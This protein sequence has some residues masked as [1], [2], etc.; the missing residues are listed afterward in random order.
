MSERPWT[1]L[2]VLRWTTGYLERHASTSPRLDAELLL[3]EVLGEPRIRLYAEFNRPLAPEERARYRELVRRRARGEP[4]QYLLERQEFWSITLHVRPGVPVP[5]ADTEVLVEEAL[6][7]AKRLRAERAAPE[8]PLRIAEVGTGSGCIAIA[9]AHELPEAR[10]AAGDVEPACLGCAHGNVRAT[11][12]EERV[13]VFEA[14][15][16]DELATASGEEGLELV[17]SNP[18]YL[19]DAERE[20]LMREVREHEPGTALFAG[21]SGLEILRPVV[22]EAGAWL[23]AGG[24]LAVEI[25][26]DEQ[27]AAVG[28][29]MREQGFEAVR[30][31]ADYG[32]ILRVVVGRRPAR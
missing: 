26:G 10:V 21:E 30:T 24:A 8:A 20:D 13:R 7:E 14:D 11:G 31:R 25:G 17:V 5:R 23:V 15:G 19:R 6:D 27:A 2:E 18:P 3:A 28:A 4:V 9:L 1:V 12:V 22:A 16:V 29:T 32:G